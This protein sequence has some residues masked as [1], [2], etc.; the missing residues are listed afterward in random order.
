ME[1]LDIFA[2]GFGGQDLSQVCMHIF[3]KLEAGKTVFL[4]I[5]MTVGLGEASNF[6]GMGYGR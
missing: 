2:I 4:F 5:C 6:A 3:F 1:A